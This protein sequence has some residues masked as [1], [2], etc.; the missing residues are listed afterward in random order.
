M[1]GVDPFLERWYVQQEAS[2]TSGDVDGTSSSG[3]P[4]ASRPLRVRPEAYELSLPSCLVLRSN[5][6]PLQQ[7]HQPYRLASSPDTSDDGEEGRRPWAGRSFE[8]SP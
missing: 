7:L 6:H 3:D 4:R 2:V 1:Q 8:S 5:Q